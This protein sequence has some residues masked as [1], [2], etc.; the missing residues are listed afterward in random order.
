MVTAWVDEGVVPLVEALNTRHDIITVDSCECREDGRASVYFTFYGEASEIPAKAH[1]LACS[2]DPSVCEYTLTVE[3][4]M[5]S[6][7]LV[8]LST[9]PG[10]VESLAASVS[11]CT[12]MAR[13]A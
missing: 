6:Q 3:Y 5:S 7:P 13:R 10:D 1:E 9:A 2:L 11:A 12:F 4:F 8:K